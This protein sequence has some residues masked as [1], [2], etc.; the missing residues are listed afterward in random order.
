MK[1]DELKIE[2]VH[3][4]KCLQKTKHYVIAERKDS[5]S[6]CVDTDAQVDIDWSKTYTMLECCG[7]ANVTLRKKMYCSE[8][9]DTEIEYYPPAISRQLPR[10]YDELPREIGELLIEVYTALHADSRRLVLMGARAIID[11]FMTDQVGDIGGFA[12]KLNELEKN[13]VLSKKNREVLEAALE[14]GHAAAHRGHKPTPNEV[15]Q[16]IDI[17]ENLIQIY[18]LKES[19]E[20]LK[21]KI[22]SKKKP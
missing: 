12:Q 1:E 6:E 2:K 17:V 3:C 20:N 4:N 9:E 15:S 7:C 10:W 14:A 19:A 21:K 22:P 8:W 11:L 5:N 13:N 18:V 16:V